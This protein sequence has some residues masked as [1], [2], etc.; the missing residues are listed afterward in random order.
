ML[1]VLPYLPHPTFGQNELANSN[2]GKKKESSVK[3]SGYVKDL[4][5]VSVPAGDSLWHFDNQIHNRYNI[6]WRLSKT[7][8]FNIEGRNRLYFGNNVQFNP[9]FDNQVTASL[10]QWQLDW[11]VGENDSY[12]F[13]ANIDRLNIQWRKGRYQ[14]IAGKQR[15]NWGKSYVWNPNDVFNAYSFFDFV[16]EERR[17]T[18]ALLFKYTAS[19][20]SSL[21]VASDYA[22]TFD[23]LT[24]SIKYN[25]NQW[26]YDFQVLSGKHL[27]DIF[28]GVGW[29]GQVKSAGFKGELTYFQPYNNNQEADL[30]ASVSFDYTFP[31]T[32]NFRLE[33]VFNSNTGGEVT[34]IDILEPVTAKTLIPNQWALFGT[35]GYDITPLVVVNVN[36]IYYIDDQSFF[37]NPD[38]TFS[39]NRNTEF[40]VASQVFGGD[41]NSI[42]GTLGSFVFTRL[43]WSF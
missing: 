5:T 11:I 39:L 12:F 40:L 1:S 42:F 19:P 4:V 33:G 38:I 41:E 13:Y 43:K 30:A 3:L 20:L 21:E 25:F 18:D 14:V 34:Q 9:E 27:E 7:L 17:G 8:T 35:A 28:L 26:E 24:M 10:D 32:L 2:P 31:N 16:Y 29:A 37:I 22:E 36:G 23:S 15:I 6:N